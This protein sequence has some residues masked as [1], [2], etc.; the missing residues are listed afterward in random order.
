MRSGKRCLASVLA[1]VL[2]LGMTGC[3]AGPSSVSTAQLPSID[4]DYVSIQVDGQEV[5]RIPLSEPQT[6]TIDQGNGVVNVVEIT[7]HGAVMRS[8]TCHN[9]LCVHMGEVT[10]ENWEY[11]VNGAF[12]ICLP[13]RVTVELRVK[14]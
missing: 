14:E 5:R 8:S 11:R 1:V 3:G 6:V 2:M 13:N 4:G 10:T 12:I 9:Q 7:E